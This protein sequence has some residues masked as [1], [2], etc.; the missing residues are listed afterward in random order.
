MVFCWGGEPAHF[1]FVF[2]FGFGF[3]FGEIIE[4]VFKKKGLGCC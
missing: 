4:Q 1:K 3:G 2:L